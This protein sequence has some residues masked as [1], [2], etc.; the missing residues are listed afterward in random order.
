DA[1]TMVH[2]VNAATGAVTYHGIAFDRPPLNELQSWS[3]VSINRI[4]AVQYRLNNGPWQ[5]AAPADGVFDSN[6]EEFNFTTPAL[7][8]G[9]YTVGIQAVN[10]IGAVTPVAHVEQLAISGS[11]ITNTRPFASWAITPQRAM[12]GSTII[13]NGGA[14]RDLEAGALEYSWNWGSTW[15]PFS[16]SPASTHSFTTPGTYPVQLRVRDQG[17]LIHLV[18]K[19]VTITAANTAPVAKFRIAPGNQH[20]MNQNYS[21]FLTAIG[22]SD[23]E[24]PFNQLKVQWDVDCDGWDA[25]PA[26]AKTKVV[27]LS[28]ANYP[29]SDRRCLKMRVID[30]ANNT[31]EAQQFF[32]GVPYNHPP[33]INNVSFAPSGTD[34]MMTV[35]GSDPD[36]ATTW[37][38]IIEYRFDFDGDGIWDTTFGPSSAV[39][40]PSA[41]RYTVMVEI[42]DRFNARALWNPCAPLFC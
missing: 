25:P 10:T 19:T 11:S 22:S 13:A 29:R 26:L 24:T 9:T 2:V 37:D 42:R 38:G 41:Y 18:A 35:S 40:V 21:V 4:T 20:S 15:T 39:L 32:S 16:T 7:P 8:N 33:A 23:V 1:A 31:A 36:S 30:T 3:N 14:S 5:D 6:S 27:A 34:Y 17:G 12:S 28:N